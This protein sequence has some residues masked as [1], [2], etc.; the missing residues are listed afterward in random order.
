MDDGYHEVLTEPAEA[1][2]F[3]IKKKVRYAGCSCGCSCSQQTN[4][5]AGDVYIED[6]KAPAGA[7]PFKIKKKVR[8]VS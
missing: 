4:K 1:T 5:N 8:Y 2:P 7:V 6:L 3:V